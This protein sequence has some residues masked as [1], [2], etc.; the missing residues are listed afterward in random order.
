MVMNNTPL[1]HRTK[2]RFPDD[3][4]SESPRSRIRNFNECSL[5]TSF[6]NPYA[7]CSNRGDAQRNAP[8]GELCFWRNVDAFFASVPRLMPATKRVCGSLAS[9]ILVSFHGRANYCRKPVF[10]VPSAAAFE[11]TETRRFSSVVPNLKVM[12]ADF[13]CFSNHAS[14]IPRCRKETIGNGTSGVAVTQAELFDSSSSPRPRKA[15][16]RRTDAPQF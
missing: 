8:L 7:R 5:M 2:M 4:R 16:S 13:A 6:A 10:G 3:N 11:G 14:I 1:W 15:R 9:P 12:A